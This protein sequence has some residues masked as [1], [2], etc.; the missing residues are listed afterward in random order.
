MK[1]FLEEL[2]IAYLLVIHMALICVLMFFPSGLFALTDNKYYLLLHIF[3]IPV[4]FALVNYY[5]NK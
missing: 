4:T 1:R 2:K 3:S 5:Y